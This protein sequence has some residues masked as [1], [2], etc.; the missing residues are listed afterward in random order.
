MQRAHISE[1]VNGAC[2]RVA[3][4]YVNSTLRRGKRMTLVRF[5]TSR[6][7]CLLSAAIVCSG[8]LWFS[9]APS[10][11][12]LLALGIA[13]VLITW[14]RRARR[15]LNAR[16]ARHTTH[17]ALTKTTNENQRVRIS[18][19]PL[20][21]QGRRA[22]MPTHRRSALRRNQGNSRRRASLSGAQ[23]LVEN[24]PRIWPSP[25]PSSRYVH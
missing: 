20:R 23:L 17:S 3:L 9:L 2:F 19:R 8:P 4:V 16:A 5:T 11:S 21:H 15:A 24:S 10:S 7:L 6:V 18:A 22:V 13:I 1:A 12:L 25:E 14:A